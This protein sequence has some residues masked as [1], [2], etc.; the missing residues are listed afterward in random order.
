MR[1]TAMSTATGSRTRST[2][3]LCTRIRIRP[4]TTAMATVTSAIPMTTTTASPTPPTTVP[5]VANPDQ[6]NADG[7]ALG[8]AC[9]PNSYPPVLATAATDADGTEG[10]TLAASGA[11]TDL[12]G[13][14]TLT[15]ASDATEGT[16]TDQWRWHMELESADDG[17]RHRR[18]D[19]SH[20]QRRRTHRCHRCIR[21]LGGERRARSQRTGGHRRH[22]HGMPDRE[23]GWAWLQLDRRRDRRH[24]HRDHRLGGWVG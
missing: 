11:F 4:T 21:L 15:I 14:G 22:C 19:H 18:H 20:G 17:R 16:F 12:D 3:A 24:V 8:N 1:A 10:D 23:H 7:D 9:D 5:T 6:A 13:N 2:I